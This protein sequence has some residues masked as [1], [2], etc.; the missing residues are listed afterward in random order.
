MGY[1]LPTSQGNWD[2]GEEKKFLLGKINWSSSRVIRQI[3]SG[4]DLWRENVSN[5]ILTAIAFSLVCVREDAEASML[6]WKKK[7][8]P[9]EN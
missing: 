2:I 5:A 1:V 7:P 6:L 4:D 9:K 8:R 3:S